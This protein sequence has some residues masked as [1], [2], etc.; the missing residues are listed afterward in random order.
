M[1]SIGSHKLTDVIFGITQKPFYIIYHQTCSC[2]T[3]LIKECF[4]TC[5]G[6]RTGWHK[7]KDVIFGKAQKLLYIISSNLLR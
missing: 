5:F 2:N 4:W 6:T 1:S 7:L 3:L